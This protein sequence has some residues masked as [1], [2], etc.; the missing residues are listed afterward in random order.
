[1]QKLPEPFLD[2]NV[3]FQISYLLIMLRI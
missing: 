2:V 3:R 1:L